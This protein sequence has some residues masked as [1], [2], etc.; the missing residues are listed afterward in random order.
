[1]ASPFV[2]VSFTHEFTVL[3]RPGW[4]AGGEVLSFSSS[5]EHSEREWRKFAL[6]KF[7]GLGG[8]LLS[9][10]VTRPSMPIIEL[11]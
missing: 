9:R 8:T 11:F 5:R 1:M 3:L 7:L 6:L 4:G 2:A 10:R